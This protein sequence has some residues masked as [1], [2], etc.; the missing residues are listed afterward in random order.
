MIGVV[1]GEPPFEKRLIPGQE[2]VTHRSSGGRVMAKLISPEIDSLLEQTSRSFYLTLKVLPSKIRCQIGLLYLLAR[3]ADTIADSASGDTNQ[4]IDNIGEYNEHAQGT[5]E[6][7]PNLHD[8]AQVQTNLDEAKL[9]EKVGEVVR[10]LQRFSDADQKRIRHCLDT[11]VSGQTLDLQRFGNVEKGTITPLSDDNE[12]D[13]YTYRVAGCVGEFWTAMSLAHCIKADAET[14][15][16]M[17][18]QGVRFGKALQL[19]NILR[20]IPADLALGRC[21]IPIDSMAKN[22]LVPSD[23]QDHENMEK[24]RP[25]FDSYLDLAWG[26]LDA[27]VEYIGLLPKSQFRLRAACMLPVLIGQRTLTLLGSQNVLDGNNRVKVLRPEIKRLKNKTL[28]AMFFKKKCM[29]ILRA[30]RHL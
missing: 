22:D 17:F 9:L 19:I 30:N 11:I 28:L 1:Q 13:D 16:L 10:S 7:A 26:H 20:D 15:K 3:L 8:L 14:Q 2:Q 21:Y 27:A 18:E 25:L 4:L 6:T 29:K 5:R 12:L 23:L 24:F